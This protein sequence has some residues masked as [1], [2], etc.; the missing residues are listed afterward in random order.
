MQSA[1]GIV[2]LA[3]AAGLVYFGYQ[4]YQAVQ[5]ENSRI[6]AEDKRETAAEAM[7]E[8]A[9]GRPRSEGDDRSKTAS[10]PASNAAGAG[11]VTTPA[12]AKGRNV[13]L[14]MEVLLES[15][16]AVGYADGSLLFDE[17]LSRGTV[18]TIEGDQH[19]RL[20]VENASVVQI[21]LNG[22]KLTRVDRGRGLILDARFADGHVSVTVMH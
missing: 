18:K 9:S 22:E 7:R 10:Q 2:I 20:I 13:R 16:V 11:S 1:A 12:A 3:V 6:E 17:K 15:T 8:A 4:R 14:E 19:V 21:K 5:A